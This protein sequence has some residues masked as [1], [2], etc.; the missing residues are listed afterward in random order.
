GRL[1]GLV[2]VPA[3]APAGPAAVTDAPRGSSAPAAPKRL[4]PADFSYLLEKAGLKA[5]ELVA[6]EPKGTL[7]IGCDQRSAWDGVYPDRPELGL[8]VEA[9]AIDGRPAYFDVRPTGVPAQDQTR[10]G[11]GMLVVAVVL[12]LALFGTPLGF[13][14]H[15]VRR[16]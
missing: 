5:D 16:G 6:A 2:S 12:V 13:A 7:A 3:Q 1:I 9:G 10:P 8:R 15:H 4:A 11:P 14:L